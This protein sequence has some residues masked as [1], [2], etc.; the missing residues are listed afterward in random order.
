[1]KRYPGLL[2][3]IKRFP[4]EKSA[5]NHFRTVRADL[6]PLECRACTVHLKLGE[7]DGPIV[8]CT[9]CGEEVPETHGTLLE[10]SALSLHTWILAAHL[11]DA[12]RDVRPLDLA[13]MLGLRPSDAFPLVRKLE[14]A[15]QDPA[16]RR[17]LG[18]PREQS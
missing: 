17:L 18:L 16:H 3:T 14:V 13:R 10:D 12:H 9:E 15:L 5:R 11:L 6:A 4:D 1:M 7:G 8:A 2:R